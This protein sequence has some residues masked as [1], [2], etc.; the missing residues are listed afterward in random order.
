MLDASNAKNRGQNM[1]T[2]EKDVPFGLFARWF[3]KAKATEPSLPNAVSV[4]TVNAK[5]APSSRMVLLKH[6]DEGGFVFYTNFESRKAAQLK[7]NAQAAMLFYWRD[8][9][10]QVRIEGKI[11]PVTAEAADAYFATRPRGAQIGAWASDQSQVMSTPH[12]LKKR[13]AQVTAKY[14]GRKVPRPP[15]WSGFCL[16]P[17]YFEF[18]ENRRFRLHK[19]IAFSRLKDGR[20]KKEYLFP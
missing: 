3:E 18:W 17:S 2:A 12:Q 15:H 7:K 10:R 1:E 16:V 19:R 13:V 6:W 9:Q 8:P 14:A 20:W 11:K 5:G 4:S